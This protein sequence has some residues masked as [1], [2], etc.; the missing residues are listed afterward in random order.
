MRIETVPEPVNN[1]SINYEYAKKEIGVFFH[2]HLALKIMRTFK[3]N[4]AHWT[5]DSW[6]DL[7]GIYVH[8][9]KEAGKRAIKFFI[10]PALLLLSTIL[11]FMC[12]C[13]CSV[14][15]KKAE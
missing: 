14:F 4:K 9:E 11:Y 8:G 6:M 10:L 12:K 13:C 3:L 1:V 5:Y 2:H 7:V 15:C